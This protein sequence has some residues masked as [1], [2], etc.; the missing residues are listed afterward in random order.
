MKR[1][2]RK[3][4]MRRRLILALGSIAAILLLSSIIS[5]VEYMRMSNY[6]SEKIATNI[7]CLNQSQKLADMAS[8]KNLQ[9]LAAVMS[10]D[11]SLIP[12]FDLASF[13]AQCDTLRHSLVSPKAKSATDSVMTSFESFIRAS[14][15]FETIFESDTVDTRMWFFGEL[16]PK[17]RR[18]RGDFVILNGVIHDELR[19]NS[20]NFDA[21]FYR[22]IMPGVVSVG[23]GL[24]LVFLL[25]YF[26]TVLYVNPLYK[27]SDGLDN[28]RATGR[29]YSNVFEGDDQIA[30]IN[31]GVTELTEENLELKRRISTL[32]HAAQALH[33]GEHIDKDE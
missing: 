19:S 14:L 30:N 28:Y 18:L 21:S 24:L 29:R 11:I 4:S 12:D 7:N 13:S 20:E 5:I 32:R 10:D 1:K 23:A 9:M 26:I 33:K 16:Q 31:A 3:P 2:E 15:E 8:E 22:G 6:V 27:I 17:Y 25:M